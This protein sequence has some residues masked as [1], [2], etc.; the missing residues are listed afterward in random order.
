MS[1]ST[2]ERCRKAMP[3][4]LRDE[5]YIGV[6]TGTE[7]TLTRDAYGVI[8][9]LKNGFRVTTADWSFMRPKTITLIDAALDTDIFIVK[10]KYGLSDGL[11]E[12]LLEQAQRGFIDPIIKKYDTVPLDNP[13]DV[14]KDIEDWFACA[15]YLLNYS[16]GSESNW[17][18]SKGYRKRAEAILAQWIATEYGETVLFEV[19]ED[20]LDTEE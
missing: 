4:V 1:Y 15:I 19:S 7:L 11:L 9:V 18:K 5:E 6:F 20:P 8:S 16:P 2:S 10:C 3:T 17:I 14:I 12:D 13:P